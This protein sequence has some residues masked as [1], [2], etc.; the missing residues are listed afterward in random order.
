MKTIIIYDN[1]GKIFYTMKGNY[2]IPQGGIQY[3]EIEIPDGKEIVGIDVTDPISPQLIYEDLAPDEIEVLR[4]QVEEL[5][6]SNSE[7][8]ETLDDILLNIIPAIT[9]Q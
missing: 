9:E 1:T 6:T 2:I 8:S 4:K 3:L 7:L 5:S